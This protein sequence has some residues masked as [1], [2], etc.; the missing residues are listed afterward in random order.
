MEPFVPRIVIVVSANALVA[1]ASSARPVEAA[2]W[3]GRN[4]ELAVCDVTPDGRLRISNMIVP[5]KPFNETR[6]IVLFA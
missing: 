2:Y 4:T 5:S 1:L 6:S 3:R